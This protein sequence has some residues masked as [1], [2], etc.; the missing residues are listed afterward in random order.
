VAAV[1]RSMRAPLPLRVEKAGRIDAAR[2]RDDG[3]RIR[4]IAEVIGRHS[5]PVV[6][7]SPE[8]QAGTSPG[9]A[10]SLRSTA[11]LSA[12]TRELVGWQP[13][14]RAHRRSDKGHTSSSPSA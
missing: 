12:L 9:W 2:G 7:I 8:E 5:T 13:F 4:A 6:A 3:V 1:H 11:G 14:I 10:N